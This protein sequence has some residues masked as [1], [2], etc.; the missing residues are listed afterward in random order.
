M[1]PGCGSMPATLAQRLENADLVF[2]DG[3]VFEDD[4][5]ILAGVGSK[6]GRRMGHMPINGEGGSLAALSPL[7]IGRK[8]FVHI[9]N[10]NPIWHA[11]PERDQRFPQVGQRRGCHGHQAVGG[12]QA[13]GQVTAAAVCKTGPRGPFFHSAA[14]LRALAVARRGACQPSLSRRSRQKLIA[15][16]SVPGGEAVES[17]HRFPL[18]KHTPPG[19]ADAAPAAE[20]F[21]EACCASC[22]S[23]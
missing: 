7:S 9:N 21:Q 12:R 19:V 17:S 13:P 20:I 1:R 16:K 23:A 3:T 18:R 10:T 8:V 22:R 11:G 4:E 6:T 15:I 2:F 14:G 5:M